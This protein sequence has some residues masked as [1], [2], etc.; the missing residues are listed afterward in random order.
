MSKFA[1]KGIIA[2]V[3]A[4]VTSAGITAQETASLSVSARIQGGCVLFTS[5]AMAF[6]DLNMGS[7]A[8]ETKQV[9]ATYK[10][11]VGNTVT[12]FTVAGET[13]GSYSGIM[14]SQTTGV[15]DTIP[16]TITWSNPASYAGQGFNGAG[17]S[18]VLNGTILNSDYMSKAPA[19]YAHSVLLAI[20]Y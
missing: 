6:G 4:V 19:S 10:C 16:Y 3:L 11:A 13:D 1:V 7:T 9:T 2:A 15:T 20:N 12:S 8:N 5:G 18:V 14:T 17:Q